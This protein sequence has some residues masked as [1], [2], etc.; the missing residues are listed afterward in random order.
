MCVTLVCGSRLPE[1][2]RVTGPHAFLRRGGKRFL[3]IR[4]LFSCRWRRAI[5]RLRACSSQFVFFGPCDL[6]HLLRQG[7][8]LARSVFAFALRLS[9]CLGCS[10]MLSNCLRESPDTPNNRYIFFSWSEHT[11]LFSYG[12]CKCVRASWRLL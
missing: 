6:V 11:E 4:H 5:S 9:Y 10:C 2:V 7:G 3:C 1:S 8:T 12:V